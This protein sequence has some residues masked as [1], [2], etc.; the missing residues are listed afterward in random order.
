MIFWK[1]NHLSLEKLETLQNHGQFSSKLKMEIKREAS[2]YFWRFFMKNGF[3]ECAEEWFHLNRQSMAS[4]IVVE[5]FLPL[6]LVVV[7]YKEIPWNCII[8]LS[9][10][11]QLKIVII[12]VISCKIYHIFNYTSC[13]NSHL[14]IKVYCSTVCLRIP[15]KCFNNSTMLSQEHV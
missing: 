1:G 3:N 5:R 7:K 8:W 11:C 6:P 12:Y 9:G 4:S 15:S 2:S 10:I 13:L 14:D